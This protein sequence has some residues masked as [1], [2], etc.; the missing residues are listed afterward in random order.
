MKKIL[1]VVA[2]AVIA[3]S[4]ASCKGGKNTPEAE[5]FAIAIT[6]IT[7]T[8]ATITITPADTTAYYYWSVVAS[9]LLQKYTADSIALLLMQQE[10]EEY[11]STFES[12]VEEGYIVKGKDAYTYST[13]DP[14]T[15]YLAIAFNV[16]KDLKVTSEAVTKEFKTAEFVVTG[17]ETLSSNNAEFIDYIDAAGLF[18]VILEDDTKGLAL[19]LAFFADGL[20]GE[21]T[22]DDLFALYSGFALGN[23]E[24]S[25]VSL[26]VKNVLSADGTQLTVTGKMA[27]S[28]GIEYDLKLVATADSYA[29]AA[30]ARKIA[31]RKLFYRRA[32][33]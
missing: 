19:Y 16:D 24:Y 15:G 2:A 9:E 10:V 22:Q 4:F 33:R 31:P 1:S 32:I 13:L 21:F 28:N 27:A 25:I 30:P 3:L 11:Q 14:D 12:L 5:K 7:S 29:E 6:D 8:G 26:A 18:Q 20:E 17:H 23:K